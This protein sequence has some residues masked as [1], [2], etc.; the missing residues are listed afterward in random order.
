MKRSLS[1]I[2]LSLA[3]LSTIH[4]GIQAQITDVHLASPSLG[5]VTDNQHL[6]LTTNA[7]TTW[8]D[9]TPPHSAK[10]FLSGNQFLDAEHGFVALTDTSKSEDAGSANDLLLK[11]SQDGGT[12]WF[13]LTIPNAI[14]LNHWACCFGASVDFV[15]LDH[16]WIMARL[17]TGSNFNLGSLFRTTD[18]GKTWKAMP[19]PPL[20]VPP[21]FISRQV[22]FLTGGPAGDSFFRTSDGG[23]TW[24]PVE[25]PYLKSQC[26]ERCRPIYQTPTFQDHDHGQIAVNL[27]TPTASRDEVYTSNDAGSTWTISP[28]GEEQP[29][30]GEAGDLITV[31]GGSIRTGAPSD[32][33]ITLALH[34]KTLR[35][36]IRRTPLWESGTVKLTS[37]GF[38]SETEGWVVRSGRVCTPQPGQG[39]RPRCNVQ[40][41]LLFTRDGGLSFQDVT[42]GIEGGPAPPVS[43]SHPL[44]AAPISPCSDTWP[45]TPCRKKAPKA[46]YAESSNE[47]VG[48]TAFSIDC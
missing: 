4:T 20:G 19:T 6:L 43:Q 23:E 42:P 18:G 12:T 16:G 3:F 22:G 32:D 40:S 45:S 17:A 30:V 26:L 31:P 29:N 48:T 11:T 39:L 38:V 2:L 21:A 33:E 1:S 37:G 34:G 44:A 13:T 15:D 9:V 25:I 8:K 5:W 28:Q 10:Q 35:S 41:Q 14:F 27:L 36:Q 24:T 46:R 7:G 47:Q